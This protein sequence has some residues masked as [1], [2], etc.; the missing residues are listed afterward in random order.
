MITCH[1]N[2]PCEQDIDL[3]SVFASGGTFDVQYEINS[4]ASGGSW[5]NSLVIYYYRNAP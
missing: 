2:E 5:A 3:T 4:I 1:D